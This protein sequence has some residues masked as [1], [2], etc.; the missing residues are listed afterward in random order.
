MKRG[1]KMLS[2]SKWPLYGLM[3]SV[4]LFAACKKD[5]DTVNVHQPAAGLMAFNLAVDKSPVGFTLSSNPLGNSPI[6]YGGYTGTYLPVY[7]GT[8]EVRSFDYNTGST[9]ALN[10][11]EFKDSS[12]Y[13]VFLTGANGNYKNLVTT[14]DYTLVKPTTG[15]AW[16]RYVNAIPD[17]I[18]LPSIAIGEGS[19]TAGYATASAFKA[20]NAGS[21][22]VAANNGGGINVSRSINV[23]ENKIYTIL[24]S[25]VP[26]Q[27][28]S[29]KAVSIKYIQNGTASE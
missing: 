28:D 20:V 12:Y 18:N 6:N 3:F 10:N 1:E 24:F 14:D 9:I 25:G 27:T 2:I 23:E 11:Q 5:N 7:V 16:V 29:T 21:L 26:G 15:M 19:E 17:S 13:S 22:N 8:R 4:V